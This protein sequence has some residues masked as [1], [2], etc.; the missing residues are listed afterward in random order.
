MHL[1]RIE[2]STLAYRVDAGFYVVAVLAA[3]AFVFAQAPPG[4][5]WWTAVLVAAGLLSWSIAEYAIHR[6]VLHGLPPFRQWHEAHHDRPTAL[7]C[8]PTLLSASLVVVLVFLPMLALGGLRCA[9]AFTLGVLLGYLVYTITHHAAHHWRARQGWLQHRK[10]WHAMHHHG[11]GASSHFG[12]T[13]DLWDHVF[14]TAVPRAPT[15]D[16]RDRSR[17]A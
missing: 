17:S 10:R 2:H 9:A 12:V 5:W 3:A 16:S 8:A 14:G 13:S 15:R 7:I 11:V 4:P 1:F 6:F